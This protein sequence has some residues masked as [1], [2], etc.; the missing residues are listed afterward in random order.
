M[1]MTRRGFMTTMATAAVTAASASSRTPEATRPPN[2]LFLVSDDLR[3]MLACYGVP[4][5]HT[6]NL[7]KLVARG[8]AFHHAYC[9]QSVC[10]PSRTSVMTGL[11]PDATRIYDNSTHFRVYNP[12]VVTLPQHFRH[13]GYH[14]QA[15]GKVYHSC[16]E[17]AYVGTTLDDAPSWSAP[18]FFPSPQYYH[19]E[20]GMRAARAIFARRPQCG[21]DAG[22]GC[23][24]NKLQP[25]A[26]DMDR[27]EAVLDTWT[28]HFIQGP[29]SEAPDVPDHVPY[30][31]Q[32]AEHA[33][34]FLRNRPDTPFFLAVGF[35]KPH[36]PYVA[37]RKYWDM[38]D[39]ATLPLAL[40]PEAPRGMPPI[41]LLKEHD[42][43]AYEGV[44]MEGPV[45]DATARHLIHGYAACVSYMDAQLGRVLDE[46]DAQGLAEDTIVV[47]WGDNGYHL[48]ENSRWGKQTCFETAT[49]CPMMIAAPK[50]RDCG[51]TSH[52]PV[53]L[54]S[55]YPTLC[56]LAGLPVPPHVQGRSLVPLL[57][58]AQA[59]WPYGA[60]S[61][62]PRPVR[63]SAPD[64]KPEP[65]DCMGYTIR[66]ERH[67][68]TIWR[69]LLQPE[70]ND[71]VELYDY[72]RDP[73][74]LTNVAGKPEYEGVE[75]E[76]RARLTRYMDQGRSAGFG[77]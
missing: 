24:H 26:D 67:R 14:T 68:L 3:P 1:T 15:F 18:S 50:A 5:I 21:R 11:R 53:E 12:D 6:P 28:D 77:E 59:S 56:D 32:V 62:F 66:T 54:I 43:G 39:P 70:K 74:E 65:G 52:R 4:F 38:Y 61:Q 20:E 25:V 64:V 47:F 48:G 40:N 36:T 30:D 71:G 42:H 2:V 46:L 8:T 63:L 60:Y 22:G 45:D 7:D 17:R 16:F 44:A 37:P 34:T 27:S 31:G 49:R 55:L 75:Q 41:A 76:L 57:D 69:R 58:D 29:I 9:Q 51:K 35:M 33:V 13:H 72:E 73:L 10:S 19:S 23:L